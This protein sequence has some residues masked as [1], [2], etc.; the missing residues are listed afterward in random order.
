MNCDQA[1]FSQGACDAETRCVYL[2]H[3]AAPT[4][5]ERGIQPVHATGKFDGIRI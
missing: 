2:P 1:S 4:H 5:E 3:Q